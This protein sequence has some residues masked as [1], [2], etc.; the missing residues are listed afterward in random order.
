MLPI[1]EQHKAA[2]LAAHQ[3]F[4]PREP[5]FVAQQLM[6]TLHRQMMLWQ[7]WGAAAFCLMA[8]SG[9]PAYVDTQR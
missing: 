8:S 4:V 9:F 5:K 1:R 3:I 6:S 7:H 2:V